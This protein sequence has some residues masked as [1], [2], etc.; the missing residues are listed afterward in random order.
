MENKRYRIISQ[1]NNSTL[2]EEY[3]KTEKK[4]T[5]YETEDELEKKFIKL[6]QEQG[7]EY[8]KIN[9]EDDL[10]INLRKQIE[11][12]NNYKFSDEE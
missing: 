4:K 3:I 1:N 5:S 7:Y 8:L 2:V 12:L 11:K 9:N 10:I 6:L